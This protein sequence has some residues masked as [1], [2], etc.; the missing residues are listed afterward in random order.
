M[1]IVWMVIKTVPSV[2]NRQEL[3]VGYEKEGKFYL[4]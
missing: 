1:N 3:V 2:E 4:L